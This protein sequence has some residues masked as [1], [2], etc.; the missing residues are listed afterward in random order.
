MSLTNVTR[1]PS[2][3]TQI[4]TVLTLPSLSLGKTHV[5]RPRGHWPRL[6]VSSRKGSTSP[7]FR[8]GWL[9]CY[10]WQSCK[11][12]KYSSRHRF[13]NRYWTCFHCDTNMS[14]MLWKSTRIKSALKSFCV[15]IDGSSGSGSSV[16][17]LPGLVRYLPGCFL[18]KHSS[19]V[20][21]WNVD[22]WCSHGC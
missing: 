12:C 14:L 1:F 6:T 9:F 11:F 3:M 21:I 4:S 19:T 16:T 7:V 22:G 8:S 5:T 2:P 17:D 15:N 18:L 13:Q 10:L 20:R